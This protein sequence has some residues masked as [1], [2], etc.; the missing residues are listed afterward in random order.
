MEPIN[1]SPVSNEPETASTTNPSPLPDDVNASASDS[2]PV[3][4]VLSG[5]ITPDA[6]PA[7][8]DAP[9]T[10]EIPQ[11]EPASIQ[12]NESANTAE[13]VSPAPDE[14]P[15]EGNFQAATATGSPQTNAGETFPTSSDQAETPTPQPT[16]VATPVA[17]A[18][19]PPITPD[20]KK[21][22]A[23]KRWLLPLV[24]GLAV[25]VLLSGA[26]VFGLYL[27]NRPTA[28]YSKS[29]S[30]TAEATDVLVKYAQTQANAK[31]TGASIDGTFNGKLSS[32]A[33][34]GTLKAQTDGSNATATITTDIAG[35]KLSF[36]ARTIKVPQSQFPDIYA[37]VSGLDSVSSLLGTSLASSLNNQWI[38]LDHTLLDSLQSSA[39]GNATTSSTAPT[40]S[41]IDD[42]AGKVQAVN[43]EYLF[44]NNT[45]E[46]IFTYGS[47]V[48]TE[49]K[50]GQKVNHYKVSYNKS[51]L[52]AYATAI[53]TALDGSSL[54]DWAKKQYDGKNISDVADLSGLQ[55]SIDSS[56]SGTTFDMYVNLKTKL[57][58]SFHYAQKQDTGS[59]VDAI[60]ISQFYAGSGTT[61]PFQLD[62]STTGSTD[63]DV[64]G[65]LK[66]S[67]DTKTNSVHFDGS[68]KSLAKS[69]DSRFS[70]TLD[71]K[72]TTAPLTVTAPTGAKSYSDVMTEIMGS[73]GVLGAETT[74]PSNAILQGLQQQL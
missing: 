10:P 72:P 38:V 71:A 55:K 34:D 63:S 54:N 49:T 48:G 7:T 12:T 60:T 68:Y 28:V 70:L 59:G 53:G 73:A 35:Q 33:F 37:K 23:K 13:Q 17:S 6:K 43:R 14:V 44:S 40:L 36:E 50:D 15:A 52:K 31:Y 56:K 22:T 25:L 16:D 41:Q 18:S 21:P 51:H 3:S 58:Q 24:V 32:V 57:V 39:T 9:W 46:A 5:V 29:M 47:F 26:Y 45:D 1:P 4:P 27:P 20:D 61:Y 30:R 62:F 8:V 69:N 64:Q 74:V 11:A 2:T 19:E 67:V 65:T 42:A 66:L